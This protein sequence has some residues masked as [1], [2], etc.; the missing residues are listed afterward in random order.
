MTVLGS[1]I[2]A[3]VRDPVAGIGGM[4]HFMLPSGTEER[5]NNWGSGDS[6][7]N[8]YGNFAMENLLNSLIKHGARKDRLEVKVFGG[9]SV[10]N[11][12]SNVGA[13]NIEF[14]KKYLAMENLVVIASDVGSDCAR[15]VIYDPLTGKTRVKRLRE[16]YTGLVVSQEKELAQSLNQAPVDGSVELFE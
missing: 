5:A 16:V 13:R 11:I 9:G 10:L 8:R 1:C 6:A 2:A 7:S 15:K 3:C 4:N 12:S 14:A